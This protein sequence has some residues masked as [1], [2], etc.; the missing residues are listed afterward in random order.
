[1]KVILRQDIE[2]LGKEGEVID[3]AKGYGR[4]FLI[5][6]GIAYLFTR[7]KMTIW[8]NEKRAQERK[9]KKERKEWERLAKKISEISLTVSVQVGEEGKFYRTVTNAEIASLLKEKHQIEVEKRKISLEA[10]IK[11]LGLYKVPIHLTEG[12]ELLLKVWVIKGKTSLFRR[13]RKP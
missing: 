9:L 2:N 8:E 3:V 10:P 6:K 4:N 1:M 11:E 5:P 13:H 7:Q 12:M